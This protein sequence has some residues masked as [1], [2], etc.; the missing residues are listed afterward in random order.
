MPASIR[1]IFSGL[2][3]VE[4]QA[5]LDAQLETIKHFEGG[6]GV[7]NSLGTTVSPFYPA[8]GV[9]LLSVSPI[10]AITNGVGKDV[11]VLTGSNADETTL[12]GYGKVDEEKLNRIAEGL[13]A[14]STLDTYRTTRPGADSEQLLIAIT[15]DHMFRMPALRLAERRAAHTADTWVYQFNWES[16]AFNGK[17]KATHALEIPFAFDTLSAAGVDAFIG[18]GDKPQNVADVMHNAWI[19]FIRDGDPGWARYG[20]DRNTMLFDE[21]SEVRR[22]PAPEERLA[23]ESIR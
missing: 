14:G 20:E 5:I 6:A 17:L 4:T 15:T 22:D 3:A 23:W 18:P 11:A 7:T 21:S 12:W 2:E 9:P 13:G 10:E 8:H 19:G 16:R 1:C